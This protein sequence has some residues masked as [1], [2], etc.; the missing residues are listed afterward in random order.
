MKQLIMAAGFLIALAGHPFAQTTQTSGNWSDP[1][2]WSGGAVPAAGGTVTVS[3][4]VTIDGN[5]SPNGSITFN[6]NATDQPGG[7]AYTFNPSGGSV[8]VNTGSIVTFEGGTSTTPNSFTGGTIDIY[9]TLILGYT[10]LLNSGSL[11]I[12]IETGGTLIIN[13]DLTNKNNSGTFTVNG[14][15]IVNGDFAN[16]TGSVTVGGTGT[17]N[18][19]GSLTTTGGS[20]VFGTKNDCN[21]G[22]CS[23][24]T[25]VCTFTNTITPASQ[26]VCSGSASS[27]ITLTS[28]NSASSPTYQWLSSTDGVTFANAPGTSTGS[29][30]TTGV[31][32]QNTWYEVRV[33]GGGCTSTSAAIEIT[34]LSGGGWQGGTSNDW[35]TAANWCSLTVP[36]STTDVTITNA[37][38]IK[39]MPTVNAG[40][41]ATAR[42][43]TISNTFPASTLTIAASATA[44]L[45]VYGNLTVNGSFTDNSTAATAGV[46]MAGSVA[47]NINGTT[48]PVFNDLT[49]DNASGAVPAV[50]VP[51]NNLTVNSILTLTAGIVNLDGN[52]LTLGTAGTSTGTLNY[53]SGSYVFGGNIVRWFPTTAITLGTAASLFPIGTATDYRPMYFGSSGLTTAGTIKVSHADLTGTTAVSFTDAGSTIQVRSNSYWTVSTGSG[54]AGTGSPFTVRTEGTGFGQVGSVSDLRLTLSAS[55]A[56]GTAGV[57]ANTT[58][59]PQINRTTFT[60]ANLPN[61]YY[62]G[63]VNPGFTTLP[64]NLVS[65]TA[66]ALPGDI[67]LSWTTATETDCSY[68][69]L[70]R[71]TDGVNYTAIA[72]VPAAGGP[73]LGHQYAYT[74]YSPDPGENYYRLRMVSYSGGATYSGIAMAS[75]TGAGRLTLFPNPSDGSSISVSITGPAGASSADPSGT[76]SI[77]TMDV[78]NDQG[79]LVRHVSSPTSTFN[80]QFTP[81]LT[82]GIYI[83]RVSSSAGFTAVASFLVRR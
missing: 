22:P 38:G 66:Q 14:A 45:H 73:G 28:V 67:V 4:P 71:S 2:I 26:A 23:G 8:T 80:A 55:A 3:N 57:N 68:F 7:T 50:I 5:L 6:S 65:F 58:A 34:V 48:G 56:S 82:P 64:V 15:L 79:M 46:I 31:L 72:T 27:S 11:N 41:A 17:I 63:S 74:D 16:S 51:A 59:N 53:T 83:A 76:A 47:Q 10:N 77:Y 35:G 62:W 54:I 43:L 9:G 49:I 13:G 36:T 1:T 81:S 20:T 60:A 78:Y 29:T 40:T 33:S 12:T 37:A 52:T 19:T 69:S 39:N 21:T 42:N 24:T 44:S 75:I 70:E 32:T 25:L 61:T 30:Y 18:T